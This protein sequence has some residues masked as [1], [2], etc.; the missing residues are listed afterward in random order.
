M[1]HLLKHRY[2]IL[3]VL[4]EAGGFGQTFLAEVTD[5]PSRRR[6]VIKKLRPIANPEDFKLAQERFQREAAVL[7]RLGESS[8]QIP[9]LYAYFVEK[10]DLYLVQELI[11]GP[12]LRQLVRQGTLLSENAVGEVLVDLLSVLTYVHAQNVIHRDVK[13]DNVI[14]RQRDNKPV[15]IDF[16]IVKE[17]LCEGGNEG[18]ARSSIVGTPGYISLE[19]AAGQP[20]FA[21]DLY[22]L[23]ATAIFLLTG[24]NPQS[25]TDPATGKIRWRPHAPELSQ[26]FASVLDKA[27]EP[28]VQDRYQTCT[29]M[30]EDLRKAFGANKQIVASQR[31]EWPAAIE[32]ETVVRP[33]DP[34]P[35]APERRRPIYALYLGVGATVLCLLAVIGSAAVLTRLGVPSG[36]GESAT[37]SGP[38]SRKPNLSAEKARQAFTNKA[39]T[40]EATHHR[41]PAAQATPAPN[42]SA[43]TEGVRTSIEPAQVRGMF[44]E[45][46]IRL[47]TASDLASRTPWELRVMRNEIFARHGYIFKTPEMRSYFARQQ[48]YSPRY[49]DVARLLSEIE[50]R[51]AQMITSSE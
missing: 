7:E 47:L 29:Q 22:S 50:V 42:T 41:T 51:N 14:L 45:A 49:D 37:E 31:P 4:S 18:P 10:Q 24:K 33:A 3:Q 19:Q 43:T 34:R 8:D 38:A 21:S 46:S 11:E 30:R 12:T 1:H 28:Y 13:P 48:W 36:T 16:G 39:T 2:R 17:V 20:V 23:G 9:K 6:C 44:P 25:M 32:E 27:T 35:P 5:T 26:E 15:L 40:A